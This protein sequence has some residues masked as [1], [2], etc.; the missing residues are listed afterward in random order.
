MEYKVLKG[1]ELTTDLLN[2][3][4]SQGWEVFEFEKHQGMYCVVFAKDTGGGGGGQKLKDA[5]TIDASLQIIDKVLGVNTSGEGNIE[6]KKTD[7]GL[8]ANLYWYS[9]KG[10]MAPTE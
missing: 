2:K 9:W 3:Y 1:V 4:S 5:E 6:L 8:E 10:D 7:K